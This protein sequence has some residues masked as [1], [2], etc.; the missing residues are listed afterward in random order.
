M[1]GGGAR[2]LEL[3]GLSEEGAC[4]RM[5]FKDITISPASACGSVLEAALSHCAL[6]LGNID[7][8]KEIWGDSALYIDTNDATALADTINELMGNEAMRVHYAQKA[9]EQAKK[10]TTA[11]MAQ[12]Y[13]KVYSQL[14]QL[15]KPV[16]HLNG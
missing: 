5:K 1:V 6:V 14:L 13:L 4:T 2:D 9:A 8:L 11:A 16:L 12:Q 15:E 3:E 7:S 10:Y